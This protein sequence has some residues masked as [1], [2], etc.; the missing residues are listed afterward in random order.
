[1]MTTPHPTG[2]SVTSWRVRR[3]LPDTALRP[4]ASVRSAPPTLWQRVRAALW[5]TPTL[6]QLYARQRRHADP[7]ATRPVMTVG[8]H[9]ALPSVP[10]L[11][12]PTRRVQADL[13]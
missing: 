4:I 5:T 9:L 12:R 6:E 13:P 3:R 7:D 1:M 11:T 8:G 10:D 2:P